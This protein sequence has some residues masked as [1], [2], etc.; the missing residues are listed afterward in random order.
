[1]SDTETGQLNFKKAT[2]KTI[3]TPFPVGTPTSVKTSSGDE[4]VVDCKTGKVCVIGLANEPDKEFQKA[5]A[6]IYRKESDIP[7]T[8]PGEEDCM[9]VV[10]ALGDPG[11]FL[12]LPYN[13]IFEKEHAVANARAEQHPKTNDEN[14]LAVWFQFDDQWDDIVRKVN[15]SGTFTCNSQT[16]CESVS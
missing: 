3:Y 1:M 13:F 12:G 4:E 9:E 14:W 11:S 10:D 7:A 6:R 5:A 8:F 16:V 15:F 2:L